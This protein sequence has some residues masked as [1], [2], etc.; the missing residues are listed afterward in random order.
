MFKLYKVEEVEALEDVVYN[1]SFKFKKGV[2]YKISNPNKDE[3]YYKI[4][5]NNHLCYINKS[6]F[7]EVI[8]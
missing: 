3:V 7:K 5:L 2:R 6:K 4:K 1:D 8:V